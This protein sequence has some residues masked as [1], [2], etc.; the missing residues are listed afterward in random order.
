MAQLLFGD[1]HLDQVGRCRWDPS[2][3]PGHAE[4]V[5]VGPVLDDLAGFD[6]EPVG[7]GHREGLACWWEHAVDV[8]VGGVGSSWRGVATVHRR[9]HRD[10]VVVGHGVVDVVVQVGE[11]GA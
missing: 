11:G 9:V 7:L 8:S 2:E 4:V 6:P 10:Q 1:Q 5:A 3:L